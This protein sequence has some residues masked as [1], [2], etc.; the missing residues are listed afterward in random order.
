MSNDSGRAVYQELFTSNNSYFFRSDGDKNLIPF[1]V[2]LGIKG[3]PFE[4]DLV[5]P[6]TK[7]YLNNLTL[8]KLLDDQ[9]V[10]KSEDAILESLQLGNLIDFDKKLSR[11]LRKTVTQLKGL[12]E[13]ASADK[14]IYSEPLNFGK[15]QIK[16]H[17]IKEK[18][19]DLTESILLNL[20]YIE[21]KSQEEDFDSIKQYVVRFKID[22]HKNRKSGNIEKNNIVRPSS[23]N[24][25][26]FGPFETPVIDYTTVKIDMIK[27]PVIRKRIDERKKWLPEYSDEEL[28]FL[29][30]SPVRFLRLKHMQNRLNRDYSEKGAKK[31]IPSVVK[32]IRENA[33]FNGVWDYKDIEYLL[34]IDLLVDNGIIIPTDF[35]YFSPPYG[36]VYKVANDGALIVGGIEHI[37]QS[38]K[39]YKQGHFITYVCNRKMGK[40]G[41]QV[42]IKYRDEIGNTNKVLTCAEMDEQQLLPH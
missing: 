13:D 10:T 32:D 18:R 5:I 8:E 21:I 7:D 38:S 26:R 24:S 14:E 41:T 15:L 4:E 39:A 23:K 11:T 19:V 36:I 33:L 6:I 29:I 28:L 42:L 9:I 22:S 34:Q 25:L 37:F 1:Y 31:T 16:G 12:M 2:V 35:N 30:F 20:T 3:R 40:E 27:M 17:L